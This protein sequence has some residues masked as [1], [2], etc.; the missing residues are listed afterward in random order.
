ME[1]GD[2]GRYCRAASA[3]GTSVGSRSHSHS[4]ATPGSR[5][6]DFNCGLTMNLMPAASIVSF[7]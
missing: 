5:L 2:E 3:V 1:P 6:L 4:I 7:Y